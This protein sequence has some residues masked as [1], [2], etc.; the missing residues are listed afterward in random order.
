MLKEI[1]IT[2]ETHCNH[3]QDYDEIKGDNPPTTCNRQRCTFYGT[4]GQPPAIQSLTIIGRKWF[5]GVN[6]NTYHTSQIIVNG[7]TIHK[8]PMEYGY[9]EQYLETARQYL[10]AKEYIITE[11]Y[12]P[13]WRYCRENNIKFEYMEFSGRK[14][15]L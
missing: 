3:C 8:T 14:K 13:L 9:G 7:E 10:V 2:K 6:G 4:E 11:E 5:D 1:T 15:D 12:T